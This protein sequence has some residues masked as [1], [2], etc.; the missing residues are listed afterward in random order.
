MEYHLKKI[1]GEIDGFNEKLDQQLDE[2]LGKKLYEK[3]NKTLDEKFNNFANIF[4]EKL[5][6]M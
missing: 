1:Q 4:T 5:M 2:K 6:G 3:L